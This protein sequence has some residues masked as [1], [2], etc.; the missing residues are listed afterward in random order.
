MP[1]KWPLVPWILTAQDVFPYC[2]DVFDVMVS[3]TATTAVPR[4]GVCKPIGES[5]GFTRPYI[6]ASLT[7]L[8]RLWNALRM[9]GL[10][11]SSFGRSGSKDQSSFGKKLFPFCDGNVG[12]E[13]EPR[14]LSCLILNTDSK[15]YIYLD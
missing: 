2:H 12:Q 5:R 4:E 9:F 1:V 13:C 6:A 15:V 10:E 3:P 11:P 14:G 8:A 7:I